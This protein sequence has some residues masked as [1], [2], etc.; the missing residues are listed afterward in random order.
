MVIKQQAV[1][2]PKTLTNGDVKGKRKLDPLP[3][4][5]KHVALS[6]P[7]T[8]LT[9]IEADKILKAMNM[10]DEGPLS[11]GDEAGFYELKER[12]K[13]RGRK[14]AAEIGEAELRKRKVSDTRRQVK[15]SAVESLTLS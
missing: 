12:Y 1:E 15:K 3:V 5:K 4:S 7:R 9:E 6:K 14:R 8:A 11:D 2:T 13:Q 10:I